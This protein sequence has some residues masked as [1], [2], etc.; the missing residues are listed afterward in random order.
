[1]R[2]IIIGAGE[3]GAELAAKLSREENDV[4]VI[5]RIAPPCAAAL[6]VLTIWATAPAEALEVPGSG[7]TSDCRNPV[8]E[9]NHGLLGKNRAR[10]TIARV[11]H[12]AYDE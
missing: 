3:V 5:D 7:V 9:I 6:D 10:R 12:S 11:R 2:I 8:D 1:M 4:T